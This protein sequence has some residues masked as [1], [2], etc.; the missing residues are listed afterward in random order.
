MSSG[1]FC[2]PIIFRWTVLLQWKWPKI[3]RRM[4]N[5]VRSLS[6]FWHSA[7]GQIKLRVFPQSTDA[8]FMSRPQLR[9]HSYWWGS[10]HLLE[11]ALKHIVWSHIPGF[12]NQSPQLFPNFFEVCVW[13]NQCRKMSHGCELKLW[14][15]HR[16][17][18]YSNRRNK[19]Y[20]SF[21]K[22]WCNFCKH[23]NYVIDRRRDDAVHILW[24]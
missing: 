4:E 1:C 2:H 12:A 23:L 18:L 17:F 24:G 10:H 8:A 5:S 3:Q 15:P 9:A 20:E 22:V 13:S 6:Y 14:H 11:V 21:C 16:A 19:P 7:P